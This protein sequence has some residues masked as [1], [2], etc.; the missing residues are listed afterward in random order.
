MVTILYIG[1]L[2]T[3]INECENDEAMCHPNA[4]CIDMPQSYECMCSE[5]YS[6]DGLSCDSKKSALH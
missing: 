4:I 5:G 1:L 6:G 2:H 3:G